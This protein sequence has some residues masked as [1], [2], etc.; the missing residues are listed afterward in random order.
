LLSLK[1]PSSPKTTQIATFIEKLQRK[2]IRGEG[3]EGKITK[4]IKKK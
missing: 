1:N 4:I 3:K 2:P